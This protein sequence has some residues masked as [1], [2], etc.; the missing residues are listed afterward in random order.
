LDRSEPARPDFLGTRVLGPGGG[1][2]HPGGQ[3]LPVTLDD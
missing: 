2:G 3:I 1:V